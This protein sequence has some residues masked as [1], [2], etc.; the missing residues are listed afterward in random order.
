VLPLSATE[1]EALRNV[2]SVDEQM[3]KELG[4]RSIEMPGKS[5]SEAINLP[6][7]N[8][9]GFQSGNVGKMASNQIPTYATAVLDLRL[10][11]GNDWKRQQDKVIEHIKAQGYF[12]IDHEP[13]EEDRLNHDK[14][15]KVIPG[16]FGY[17]AQRTSMELPLVKKVIEAVQLTTSDKVVLQPTM[18]GSLPLYLFE[19]YLNAKT[20]SVPIANHDNNQHAENENI[21]LKNL[22][23]GIETMASLMMIKP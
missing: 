14:L 5:L 18:G 11:L 8:I 23:D 17:N 19:K 4:L 3:K 7:L 2:P 16:K 20:I 22:F 21:R 13:I 12:V 9:N 15:I 1:K 6:S 10:V